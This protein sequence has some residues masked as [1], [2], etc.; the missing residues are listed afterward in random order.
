[1]KKSPPTIER[2]EVRRQKGQIW[3]HVR[4]KWLNETPEEAVRQ[5]YLC[6]LVN[7]YGFKLEQIDEEA[8]L[9]G[10]R[11]N[12][13]AR[14]D[15]VIWRTVEEKRNGETAL[16][17]VECKAD[18]VA[19]DQHA[20]DQ[21]ANYANNERVKFFVAHN[22]RST[23]Y[24]KVDL[25]KRAPNY[26]E[27]KDIPHSDASHKE[28]E[29]LLA[30]LKP[31]EGKEFADL[32]HQCH[33]VIRNNEH[34]DPAAAFDEI[35]KILF[36]KVWVE[37]RMKEKRER[38]NLFTLDYLRSLLG[39]NPI[40]SLFEDTKDAYR[41]DKIFDA[42]EKINLRAA[43]VEAIV[44]KLESYNLSETS[45][46][47]K[48]IAFERFL[49]G[50]FRG[51]IGQFFTPRPVVDF[52]VQMLEPQEG[53]IICDPASGS[54]GFLIRCFEILRERI[55]A[56]VDAQYRAF[57]EE[58]DRKRI[59]E[60]E[61]ARKKRE[62]FDELQIQ[63]DPFSDPDIQ[64]QKKLKSRIWK[65]SNLCIYGTDANDR[66]ARTSKMNMIMHGDG[67]GGV[68][69]HNGLLNV[70]GIFEG[71]FNVI[72]TNPP[73]GAVVQAGNKILRSDYVASPEARSRYKA[74]YGKLY[75]DAIARV[76]AAEGKPILSLF[77][78]PL[79]GKSP[80]LNEKWD[81]EE[82]NRRGEERLKK[83]S[84]KTELVFI[85][86]CLDLLAPGGRLGIVLPEGIFNNPSLSFVREFTEDRAFI[87]AVVS[88]PQETFTS[89][90]ASVKCSIL[91][92]QKFSEAEQKRYDA[93]RRKA[94]HDI[95]SK[96]QP[97]IDVAH[98]RLESEMAEAKAAK[99]KVRLG[100]LRKELT[101]FDR[102]MADMIATESRALLKQRFDYP[103]FLYEAE[104]VGISA[105]GEPDLNEL[106]PNDRVPNG[107]SNT[108]LEC[109]RDFKMNPETYL[110]T[111]SL[112]A[113]GPL[114][115]LKIL[116]PS[117]R[118]GA[119]ALR[120]HALERWDTFFYRKDFM[121][122]ESDLD[123]V[124]HLSLGEIL[125][126]ESR[127]WKHVDFENGEFRYIEIGAV[128]KEEGI[129]SAQPIKVEDAPS[130]ATTLVQSGDII[131]STT[132]P[133][134]GAFALVS[135][136]YNGCVCSSGF[137]LATGLLTDQI[138]KGFLLRFLR[139][140]AGLKQME[141][142]MTGGLYPAIVQGE[143]E[144]IRVPIL[145]IELQK[146][147]A[148]RHERERERILNELE[149]AKMKARKEM[150]EIDKMLTT[151]GSV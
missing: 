125:R 59:S 54:G 141:R 35:A 43:T 57:C 70:N 105:T 18:N 149:Q 90:G 10:K 79:R 71:R 38:K 89:S 107:V 45:E 34:L 39:K 145:D 98:E 111:D 86:R 110:M 12:K 127:S 97:G 5:E 24:F 55:A 65:L 17:V 77:K 133:Y 51:E 21:G 1:M 108:C 16:I 106:Y 118:R 92:A 67:H 37:R 129:R 60:A 33:N 126:F 14:A 132:R 84:M 142:R 29:A 49:G 42:D 124:D 96:H 109:Y 99:D 119:F 85:E 150:D 22:R 40:Q 82:Q 151:V 53:E 58:I 130:R 36:V 139:S 27:V 76:E 102:K 30:Q 120:W 91:F 2:L 148:E 7:E 146:S 9:P 147:I 13:H 137:A 74:L 68:H 94:I 114:T 115:N 113:R 25:K 32:L 121:A 140:E 123:Q 66:M 56:D 69:H 63:L 128:T 101:E 31:F 52:M 103:I 61:R 15:F 72:A 20:Y 75:D 104:K 11:G 135:D 62:K 47:V 134:L 93:I 122:L 23:K 88:L 80:E 144:K 19:I 64:T 3:S 48:G 41:A 81:E 117:P 131:L 78:L 112:S 87:R 143:L 44:Q 4:K 95:K 136:Q 50:T 100:E 28:I 73:F 83:I 6:V 26:S 138:D 8:T 116:P 46:D